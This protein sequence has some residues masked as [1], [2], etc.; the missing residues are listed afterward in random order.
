MAQ[1]DAGSTNRQGDTAPAAT[2]QSR[3]TPER[4]RALLCMSTVALQALTAAGRQGDAF[5][6]FVRAIALALPAR[7]VALW[8]DAGGH[9]PR[10]LR[11]ATGQI[12]E[13]AG[14][15]LDAP[16]AATESGSCRAFALSLEDRS[17]G[18]LFVVTEAPLSETEAETLEGLAGA[19]A[20]ALAGA[21][22]E[23]G[24][25]ELIGRAQSALNRQSRLEALVMQA[26]ALIGYLRGPNHVIELINARA[27]AL[28]AD[29]QVLGRA[30]REALP[31][32]VWQ[33]LVDLLDDTFRAGR[34]LESHE[35]PIT[36]DRGADGER[37][38]M[39]DLTLE[40]TRDANGDVEGIMAHAADVTD[41]VLARTRMEELADAAVEERD[42]LQQVL[43]ALPEAVLIA[44]ATSTFVMA[45][46]AAEE[47]LGRQTVGHP[48]PV[49]GTDAFAAFGATRL[50]GSPYPSAELPLE[51]ALLRG[52]VVRGDQLLL[53][54]MRTG[55]DVPILANSAPLRN[56]SGAITG[57]V[58]VFQDIAEIKQIERSR[59]EFI[60]VV[61]HDL[62]NPLTA[63]IGLSQ[64]LIR[65]ASKAQDG[66]TPRL[67]EALRTIGETANQMNR[68]IRELLDSS[69]LQMGRPLDLEIAPVDLVGLMGRLVA[70]YEQSSD[71]HS[72]RL[73]VALPDLVAPIDE[74][75]I[76]RA[77]AN[78]LVNALKYSPAGGAIT[79]SLQRERLAGAPVA[80]VRIDDQGVG[81]PAGELPRVFERF[82]R[83]SNAVGQFSGTGL[84]LAGVQQVVRQHGGTVDISSVEGQGTSV[85]V[86]L[87]LDAGATVTEGP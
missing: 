63:I 87:P 39:L 55:R 5:A 86:L 6:P 9:R 58:V 23:T 27:S 61:S 74:A 25:I 80:V 29:R 54:N 85:R 52:E 79:V 44:D 41:L 38:A 77:L 14:T 65:R 17:I 40:P 33:G 24:R 81:I 43:D 67:L 50:D 46:Q 32:L 7:G 83:A 76:E 22:A 49:D 66:E 73:Q 53:R 78:L 21:L 1:T 10:S 36:V 12:P 69:W 68:Q 28:F 84:G 18:H 62:K 45:N 11:A 60:A 56:A 34:R 72:I 15:T 48:V 37:S 30:V 57:A 19:A 3:D 75:R 4:L 71:R 16:P 82:F 8:E 2:G 42:R 20:L 51:R 64:L 70:A 47:I 13:N 26:P 59:D 35:L 31:E